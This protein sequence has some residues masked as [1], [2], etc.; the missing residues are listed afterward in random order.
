MIIYCSTSTSTSISK[1]KKFVREMVSAGVHLGHQRRNPKMM[2]YIYTKK[3][4]FQI[5]DLYQTYYYLKKASL[6]LYKISK[7]GKRVLFIGTKKYLSKYIEKI[8]IECNS[9]YITKRWLGGLLTNWNTLKHSKFK[10]QEVEF[11]KSQKKKKEI[12]RLDRQKKK[13]K[14]YLNGIRSMY[15]KPDMVIIIGQQE[16]M[17]AIQECRK[18]DIPILTILDTNCDPNLTDIFI[19]ANDDSI[20]S[21]NFILNDLSEAIQEGQRAAV[22]QEQKSIPPKQKAIPPKQKSIP[23]KQKAIPPKKQKIAIEIPKRYN[24]TIP[25]KQNREQKS[26]PK[27]ISKK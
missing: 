8:A 22:P 3:N 26:I 25:K 18:L 10:M 4:G 12:S 16:E 1:T 14:K 19:P 13:L 15:E 27:S 2:S 9:W 23:P 11:V 21:I 17:N 6:Y 24:T 7:R 20:S 5:I